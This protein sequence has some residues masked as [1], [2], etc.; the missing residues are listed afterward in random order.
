M[1]ILDTFYASG[2]PD[3]RLFTLELTCPAWTAPILICNG[4]PDY[5]TRAGATPVDDDQRFWND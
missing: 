5:L 4:Y 3:V 1:T 2:G